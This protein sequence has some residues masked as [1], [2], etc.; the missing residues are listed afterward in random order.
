MVH[1]GEIDDLRACFV[2]EHE[3]LTA[4]TDNTLMDGFV[5]D[6]VT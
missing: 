2:K 4:L 5:K 6:C 1:K 3:W